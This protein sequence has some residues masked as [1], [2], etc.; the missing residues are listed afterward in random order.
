MIIDYASSKLR[1]DFGD[2]YFNYRCKFYFG[3]SSGAWNISRLFRKPAFLINFIP[4][5]DFFYMKWEYPSIFKRL[6]FSESKKILS[7]KEMI[8]NETLFLY[9]T[10][11]YK[12]KKIEPLDNSSDEVLKLAEAAINI[13]EHKKDNEKDDEVLKEKIDK[14]HYKIFKSK[15][16]SKRQNRNPIENNFLIN[17]VI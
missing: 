4:L 14:L 5:A 13:I 11:E 7:I 1:S 8:D 15:K 16:M 2:I 9:Q 10:N 6:R 17:T 3:A 12:N